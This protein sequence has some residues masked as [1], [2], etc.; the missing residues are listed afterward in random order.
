LIE[1]ETM[2]RVLVICIG[3]IVSVGFLALPHVHAWS[4]RNSLTFI[5]RSGDPALVKLVGPSRHVVD[6]PNGK[7]HAV[8]IRGG[9]YELFVRYG[10]APRYRYAKGESF[11]IEEEAPGSY[12]KASL[13]LHGVVN[14]NYRTEGSSENEF[15]RK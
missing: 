7:D 5:N 12:T 14:G 2:K 1:E 11:A 4:E 15:S 8:T 13:T 3:I 9:Q 10:E 6:I